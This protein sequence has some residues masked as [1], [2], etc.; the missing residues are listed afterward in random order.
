MT[1]PFDTVA[2]YLQEHVVVPILWQL[3]WMKWEDL[4]GGWA[5]FAVYGAAQ[6]ALMFA[7]CMPLEK[8]LPVERWPDRSAVLTD[9]F[10]TVLQRVGL[11]PLVTFV[12]FYEA[13][14]TLNAVLTDHGIVPPTLEMLFPWLLGRPVISFLLYACLLDFAEYVRHRVSHKLRWWYAL[15]SLHHAQRQ[16]TFWSDDRNHLLDDLL[17]AV[18]FGTIALAIGVSPMQFPLL[19]LLLRLLESLSHANAR[20]D[21]GPVFGR[22]LVSPRFHR[23]HHGPGAAGRRSCN[24]GAVLPWWDMLFGTADFSADYTA[25]GDVTASET[26]ASGGYLAQQGAGVRRL[27][28]DIRGDSRQPAPRLRGGGP[29]VRPANMESP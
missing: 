19:V 22:L 25:T 29:G 1:D 4:A 18:W 8:F 23:T 11:L 20:L 24:F 14:T 17:G 12:G 21:F 27:V 10:Y 28:N 16:M 6:V 9:V 26:L 7:I 2:G 3:G 5:L 13:Q 15:H